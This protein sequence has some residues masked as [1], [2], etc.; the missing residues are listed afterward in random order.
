[1]QETGSELTSPTE[2][3]KKMSISR[4]AR[5]T[6][7]ALFWAKCASG[8]EVTPGECY[9]GMRIRGEPLDKSQI[10]LY[11]GLGLWDSRGK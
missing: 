10:S 4:F 1:M 6:A 7:A 9:N 3:G 2:R 11:S 5:M 8:E